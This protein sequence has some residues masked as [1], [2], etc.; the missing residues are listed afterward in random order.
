MYDH[1]EKKLDMS[2]ERFGRDRM[3]LEVNKLRA[4]LREVEE[5]CVDVSILYFLLGNRKTKNIF[6]KTG[7]IWLAI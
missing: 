6:R 2:I 5:K 1:F 7:N 4:Q 3:S